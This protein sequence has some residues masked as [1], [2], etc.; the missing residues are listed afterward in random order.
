LQRR[1]L[2][3]LLA[4]V[5]LPVALVAAGSLARPM[6]DERY[7]A[8]LVAPIL[9]WVGC[10]LAALG[11]WPWARVAL[12]ALIVGGMWIS[13][14]HY[15]F[16]PAYA[17]SRPWRALFAYLGTRVGPRDAV[18]YT[19]PDPAPEVYAAGR[20]P[21]LILPTE[22][23]P[24]RGDLSS[25][26]AGLAAVYER[27]WLIP[28]WSPA[29]DGEGL[30]ED[31]LD[32]TCER[33]AELHVASWP[34]VLYHTPPFYEREMKPVDA[35]LEGGIRLLGYALR[36]GEGHAVDRPGVEPGGEVR[37]T[38]YWRAESRLEEDFIVFA[39]LLD[40]TGRLRGQQDSQ[41]RQGTFPTRAWAAGDWVIDVYRIPLAADAPPGLYALE[42]G[43][44]RPHNGTRLQVSGRDA[45][46]EHSRVL[47]PGLIQVR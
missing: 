22:V 4:W 34:L 26:V 17:K 9:I 31:V 33:A 14:V 35:Q 20:W 28:Q 6:F 13:F 8:F 44:Y 1:S 40:E 37:L 10:G 11:R 18:V 23:P 36:D 39:H 7:L 27:I 32:A 19:F 46:P 15:R 47:L 21:V 43:M 5:V 2:F 38:L 29:W 24:D 25:R 45:D 42:V 3:F 12:V 30:V 16:D 41:P